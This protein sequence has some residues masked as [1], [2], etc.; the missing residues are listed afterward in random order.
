VNREQNVFLYVLGAWFGADSAPKGSDVGAYAAL[1]SL[2]VGLGG[3][4]AAD[5][6][7]RRFPKSSPSAPAPTLSDRSE[8]P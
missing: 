8:S 7:A 5:Y 6:F 3:N 1:G 4:I 2:I